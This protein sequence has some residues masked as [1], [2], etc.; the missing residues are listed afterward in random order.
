MAWCRKL[1]E[2]VKMR[3]HQAPG[4]FTGGVTM[5]RITIKSKGRDVQSNVDLRLQGC[6]CALIGES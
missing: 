2:G 1:G 5:E 3:A 4:F 6:L